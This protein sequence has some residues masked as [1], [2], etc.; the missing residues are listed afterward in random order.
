MASIEDLQAFTDSHS[1]FPNFS[2]ST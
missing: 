1:N 2:D